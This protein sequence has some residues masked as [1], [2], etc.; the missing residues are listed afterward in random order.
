MSA[1]APTV[2]DQR[3]RRTFQPR[4]SALM[5]RTFLHRA[6]DEMVQMSKAITTSDLDWTIVRFMAPRNGSARGVRRIGFFGHTKIGFAVTRAD[7]GQFTAD[8]VHDNNSLKA[9]PAI[10]N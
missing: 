2:L 9:A 7:I 4:F 3:D 10:S 1:T 5:A 8:Q 6:Y